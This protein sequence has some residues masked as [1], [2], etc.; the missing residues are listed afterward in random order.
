MQT[1]PGH[2][3]PSEDRTLETQTVRRILFTS[4]TSCD[5]SLLRS[6]RINLWWE[7][8]N[9]GSELAR[10]ESK[11]W[12]RLYTQST[13]PLFSP[14]CCTGELLYELLFSLPWL[15][16][17]EERRVCWAH[18]YSSGGLMQ[19]QLSHYMWVRK[20]QVLNTSAQSGSQDHRII[21]PTVKPQITQTENSLTDVPG[22]TSPRDIKMTILAMTMSMLLTPAHIMYDCFH[23]M[24]E[25]LHGSKEDSMFCKTQSTYDEP[26]QIKVV[27][28]SSVKQVVSTS[29]VY[30]I[31]EYPNTEIN[32]QKS[33]SGFWYYWGPTTKDS[34]R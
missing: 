28:N 10:L 6:T 30:V 16:H 17:L 34:L 9:W 27:S 4:K 20:Q 5:I 33:A 12:P 2:G 32:M 15:E 29:F 21:P 11:L 7:T 1:E 19:R 8:S 23:T 31:W 25:A 18:K 26:F 3:K 24:T 14:V 13:L 22:G